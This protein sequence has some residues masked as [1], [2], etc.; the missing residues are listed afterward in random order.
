MNEH[1]NKLREFVASRDWDQFHNP[2]NLSISIS[3]EAA[4]LLEIF[5]WRSDSEYE[6]LNPEELNRISEEIADIQI[7]LLLLADK[8]DINLSESV[9]N[10][11]S[12]NEKKYPVEKARGNATKYDQYEN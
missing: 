10:K 8:L 11:I 1:I 3:V 5:Q 7:Y 9:K 6:E 4:E 2:K 12:Q